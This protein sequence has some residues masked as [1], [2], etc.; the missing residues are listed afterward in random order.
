MMRLELEGHV[1]SKANQWARGKRG[2]YIPPGTALELQA[3]Q[4]QLNAQWSGKRPMVHPD[5]CIE[6]HLK[7]PLQDRDG[8]LKSILDLLQAAGVIHND[9]IKFC[10]GWLHIAPAVI[11]QDEKVIIELAEAGGYGWAP[12]PTRDPRLR[13]KK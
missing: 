4:F 11:S 6:F 13:A 7:N 3:L 1:P 8:A 10:N 12:V 5:I 2:T 9:N